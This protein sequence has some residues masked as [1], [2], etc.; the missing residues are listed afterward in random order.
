M[1]RIVDEAFAMLPAGEWEVKV[2][3]DSA[4][5][6][7]D[8]LDHWQGRRW[9]FAVSA[10]MSVQLRQPIEALPAD[11][12]QMWYVERGGMI[13]EWAEVPLV[14]SRRNKK[15]DSQPYRYLAVRIRHQQGELFEDGATVRHSCVVTNLW[16]MEGQQ[17]LEWP[18]G[19]VGTIEQVHH[20]L[21][22]ELAGGVYPSSKRRQCGLVRAPGAH[23]QSASIT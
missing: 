18:R 15:K 3:S 16:E 9:R 5:Y 2:R 20:I 10:D 22:S 12:W 8:V 17:L 1:K 13:R 21:V 4:V 6:Q 7:Q 11:A 14:P 19:E 23:L